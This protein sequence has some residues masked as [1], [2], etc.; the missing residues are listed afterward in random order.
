MEKIARSL[1]GL[2]LPRYQ[3]LP[4][5]GLYL[6][7]TATYI[8]EALA[9]LE[10]V[11]L[12]SSMVSNYVKHDLIASPK[13][14]LYSRQ[15]IAELVFIAVSK[16][17]LSLADLCEALKLQRSRYDTE[18]A[19]NYMVDELE[20]VLAYVFGFKGELTDVGHEH[21]EYEHGE[22]KTML[23]NI[24]MTISYKVYLDKYF[25]QFTGQE[26]E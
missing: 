4:Q 13:K 8:N 2:H 12:T 7:Q 19:Y 23:R 20:N 25:A 11:H 18:T 16:N 9:P 5:M 24:I 17:V 21:G 14:K 10:N 3:E 15:Q 26:E 1:A 6:E 22:Y